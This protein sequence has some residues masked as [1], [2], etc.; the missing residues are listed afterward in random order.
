MVCEGL[1][2]H[3]P[4]ADDAVIE[5]WLQSNICRCTSYSELKNAI[6]L[7]LAKQKA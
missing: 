7:V 4:N 3:H 2:K 6:K 5:E 1:I